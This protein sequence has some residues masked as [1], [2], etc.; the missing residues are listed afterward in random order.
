MNVDT[1]ITFCPSTGNKCTDFRE[2]KG[3]GE[4]QGNE[5]RNTATHF[6]GR[7]F[8]ERGKDRRARW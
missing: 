7:Y 8:A 5:K 4:Q 3:G 2:G 1:R 6:C